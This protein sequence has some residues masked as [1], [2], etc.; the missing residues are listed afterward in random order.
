MSTILHISP[1][2]I[3]NLTM[4]T[5][6]SSFGSWSSRDTFNVVTS[7]LEVQMHI[8]FSHFNYVKY[9]DILSF[10][11]INLDVVILFYKFILLNF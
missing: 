11:A 5:T 2:R 1:S 8:Y 6:Y 4:T 3:T 10:N 7:I 9:V